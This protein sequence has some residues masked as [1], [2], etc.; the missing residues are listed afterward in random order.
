MELANFPSCSGARILHDFFHGDLNSIKLD[1]L[2]ANA[3]A[4]RVGIVIAITSSREGRQQKAA[5]LL[6]A[7]GF[8]KVVHNTNPNTTRDTLLWVLD[9]TEKSKVTPS[10]KLLR[11]ENNF[12]PS[13]P[14][15]P[16]PAPVPEG[17]EDW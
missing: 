1:A 3:K 17:E 16:A 5:T 8:K 12:A 7:K 10:T 11:K 2:I 15:K 6:V 13:K 4:S 14:A 9:L